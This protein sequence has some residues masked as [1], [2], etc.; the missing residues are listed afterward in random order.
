[1]S[2]TIVAGPTNRSTP[3]L[4]S[5]YAPFIIETMT[6]RVESWGFKDVNIAGSFVIP[7]CSIIWN[8]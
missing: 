1:L 6:I 7:H 2:Q 5:Y 3:M 8:I 4:G